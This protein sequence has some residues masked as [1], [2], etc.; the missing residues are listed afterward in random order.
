M[1]DKNKTA[2]EVDGRITLLLD[3]DLA[4]HLGDLIL[5]TDT[6]NPALLAIGHKLK[7]EAISKQR[8]KPEDQNI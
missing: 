4:N 2:F 5:S 3:Q 7:A 6:K 1:A 8:K